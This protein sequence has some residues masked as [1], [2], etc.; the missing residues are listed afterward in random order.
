[1]SPPSKIIF[2][3]ESINHSARAFVLIASL[4]P[5]FFGYG[6]L[7]VLS[8][9]ISNEGHQLLNSKWHVHIISN[10]IYGCT[11]RKGERNSFHD[12]FE[13]QHKKTDSSFFNLAFSLL[14]FLPICSNI[15]SCKSLSIAKQK[16]RIIVIQLY[17]NF[18]CSSTA[19]DNFSLQ[20]IL[21]LQLPT[22]A[23]IIICTTLTNAMRSD[24]SDMLVEKMRPKNA[25][26]DMCY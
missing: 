25:D 19:K 9:I 2:Q 12:G 10:I 14:Y 16:M 20:I 13:E 4:R 26:V 18:S 8:H 6:T 7:L 11:Y 3:Q 1:M 24:S 17:T 21:S 5:D 23:Y 22:I 15:S